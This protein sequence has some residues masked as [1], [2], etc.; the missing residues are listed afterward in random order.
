MSTFQST[1]TATLSG[2]HPSMED[3]EKAAHWLMTYWRHRPEDGC[4][5][6]ILD[7]RERYDNVFRCTLI[8][9]TYQVEVDDGF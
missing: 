9:V 1:I 7:V 3:Y 5:V 4:I 2:A 6:T 8:L